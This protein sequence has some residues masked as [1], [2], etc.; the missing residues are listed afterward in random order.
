MRNEAL[1]GPEQALFQAELEQGLTSTSSNIREYLLP[2]ELL[3]DKKVELGAADDDE[4][5]EDDAVTRAN[6]RR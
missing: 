3:I 2:D 1:I 5:E 6:S 4:D